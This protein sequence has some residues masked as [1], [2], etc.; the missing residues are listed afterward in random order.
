MSSKKRKEE[1]IDFDC[2]YDCS[3]DDF[4]E[5]NRKWARENEKYKT[6]NTDRR[7][8]IPDLHDDDD[9]EKDSAEEYS[10]KKFY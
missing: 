10:P 4:Y 3:E 2:G 8:H 7:T 1:N 9:E 6:D 5:A